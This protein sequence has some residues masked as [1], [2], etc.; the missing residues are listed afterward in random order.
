MNKTSSCLFLVFVQ[1]LDQT[2]TLFD[3]ID[4]ADDMQA[5]VH[6]GKVIGTDDNTDLKSPSKSYIT[7]SQVCYVSITGCA[8][9]LIVCVLLGCQ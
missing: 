6:Q 3:D 2:Q 8:G 7:I 4:E 5:L 9:C 1:Y